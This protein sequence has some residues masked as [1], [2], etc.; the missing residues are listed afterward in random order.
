MRPFL[1]GLAVIAALG[2]AV[3]FWTFQNDAE[4]RNGLVLYGNVDI[5]QVNLAFNG[6]ERIA[7]MFVEEGQ[8]VAKGQLLAKLETHLLEAEITRDEAQVAAQREVVR[9]LV[10]GTRP[11]EIRQAR[12]EVEAAK[13]EAQNAERNARRLA[14]LGG[15]KAVSQKE[16]DDARAI[17]DAAWARFKAA[18]ERLK[19][20]LAGPR[21]EDIASAKA[22]LE[23]LEAQLALN[24]RRL[25]D[26][27]LYAPADG[28]VQD[29][30]L[31]PGDMATPQT[32]VYTIAL[33]DPLWVR[34]YVGE[35]DLGKIRPGMRALVSTDSFPDKYYEGW[36]GFISPTAEFTPKSVETTEVR[37]DLVYQVRVFVC[38]PQHELRLGM[39]A[40]V[41]IPLEQ[42]PVPAGQGGSPC[43]AS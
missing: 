11:E 31:E 30:I 26:A 9:R 1:I 13:T 40:T 22:T 10:T 21:E 42:P 5:R 7:G 33:T 16:S 23:A 14:R 24:Q 8:P 27:S 25:E 19:L 17:A 2:G 36:I 18:D 35:P 12:A 6:N 20:A 43:R 37:T 41:T 28:V 3:W 15:E 32:P 38:D 4:S 39:P 29:R 34:A